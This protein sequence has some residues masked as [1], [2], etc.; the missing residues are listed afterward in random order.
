M[1]NSTNNLYLSTEDGIN[2]VAIRSTLT[3]GTITLRAARAGLTAAAVQIESHPT[4]IAGGLETNPPPAFAGLAQPI[5][6]L[7]P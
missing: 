1:L 4:P 6:G 3:P 2:R 5:A 7:V